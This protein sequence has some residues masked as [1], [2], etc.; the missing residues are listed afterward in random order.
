[1]SM[2]R[3]LCVVLLVVFLNFGCV[4]NR[5]DVVV[6]QPQADASQDALVIRPT[7]SPARGDTREPEL[8]STPDGRI[9]LSWV[10]LL[11]TSDAAD[12]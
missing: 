9:I 8:T 4:R 2:N 1:M 7:E 11:Y 5:N 6:S 10:C 12:D 3:L